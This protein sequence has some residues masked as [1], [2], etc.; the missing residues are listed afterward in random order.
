MNGA[1]Q[2]PL[3]LTLSCCSESVLGSA[4]T[5]CPLCEPQ[6]HVLL[7]VVKRL[8]KMPIKDVSDPVKEEKFFIAGNVTLEGSSDLSI[9]ISTRLIETRIQTRDFKLANDWDGM[10]DIVTS[11]ENQ[12]GDDNKREEKE[13][14]MVY[15]K[16][17]ALFKTEC[18]QQIKMRRWRLQRRIRSVEDRGKQRI[19]LKLFDVVSQSLDSIQEEATEHTNLLESVHHE[20]RQ[21][22]RTN[23]ANK[24]CGMSALGLSAMRGDVEVLKIHV[25]TMAEVVE[26]V[27]MSALENAGIAI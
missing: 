11:R 23:L 5:G 8:C 12:E 25:K 21:L 27:F 14:D 13:A 22:V 20:Y 2:H 17:A 24:Q 15:R 18:Q 4:P 10:A 7:D 1:T 19:A 3:Q 6:I 26:E 16:C 9:R